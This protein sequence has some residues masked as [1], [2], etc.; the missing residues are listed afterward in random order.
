MLVTLARVIFRALFSCRERLN[1]TIDGIMDLA[2]IA[3]LEVALPHLHTHS[4]LLSFLMFM[5]FPLS[6]LR[7]QLPWLLCLSSSSLCQ[8]C[9]PQALSA[10]PKAAMQVVLVRS[11]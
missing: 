1:K 8:I 6:Y 10:F 5:A 4:R 11:T 3:M 2:F 7:T 9:P